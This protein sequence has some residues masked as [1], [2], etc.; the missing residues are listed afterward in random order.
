MKGQLKELAT[1]YGPVVLW[2]D[3]E[4]EHSNEERGPWT[5][6]RC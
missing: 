6:G 4:W 2:F 1:N 3:G 5:S